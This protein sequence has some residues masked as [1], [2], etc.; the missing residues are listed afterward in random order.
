MFENECINQ[1]GAY[2]EKISEHINKCPSGALTFFYNDKKIQ[3]PRNNLINT[4]Y[5]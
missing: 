4:G 2:T 3:L 5:L 1:N